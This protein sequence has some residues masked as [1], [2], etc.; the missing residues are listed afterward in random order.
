MGQPDYSDGCMLALYPAPGLAEAIAIPGGLEPAEIHVTI[1]YCGE[2]AGIDLT[3]L[4]TAAGQL[5]DRPPIEATVSGHARFTGGP[6]DV[7]VALI[8]SHD[9]EVLRRD[10]VQALTAAGIEIPQDHGHT[11][12][13]TQRYINPEDDDPVGRLPPRPAVFTHLT[14]VHGTSRTDLPFRDLAENA[15]PITP[16]ARE[17]YL[18]GWAATGGPLTPRVLAGCHAAAQWAAE[19]ADQPRVFEITLNLGQLEGNWAVIYQRRADLITTRTATVTTTWRGIIHRLNARSLVSK[20]RALGGIYDTG[21]TTD[22]G[23][24]TRRQEITAAALA[25]LYAILDDPRY[26]DLTTQISEAIRAGLTEGEVGAL[27]AAAE[28]AGFPA[29]QLD[30][31][32]MFTSIYDALRDLPSLPGMGDQWVQRI[33]AG[34][35]ADTGQALTSLLEDGASYT[36]ML[37]TVMRVTGGTDIRAVSV[38]LDYAI[39]GGFAQGALNLY[40]RLGIE[41]LTWLD[42]GDAKVCPVCE[43]NAA[44]SPYPAGQFPPMPAHPGCRCSP[45]PAGT[46]LPAS[47]FTQYLKTGGG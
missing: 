44:D 3:A 22:P 17:A 40:A 34:A 9:I 38:L 18:A 1:A 11:P 42:A 20:I 41:S 15:H 31:E 46:A 8:D 10:T 12:H 5:L 25:W 45:A 35:A 28:T 29:A 16:Y 47:A 13:A 26:G 2:A 14:V 19:H 21:E 36:D 4:T 30:V 33:I 43:A 27:L 23:R 39:S 7:I 24:R 32:A 6:Q 37:E